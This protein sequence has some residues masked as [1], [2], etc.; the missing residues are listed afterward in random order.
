MLALG[1][2]YLNGWAMA[3]VDGARKERAEW[4]PHPDRVF[5][6]MAAAHFET[7][8][9]ATERA[10]LE[11]LESLPPPS[12]TASEAAE[13]RTIVSYV[14]VNDTTVGKKIPDNA[15]LGK[16]KDAGLSV[17]PEYRSRQPRSFPVAIPRDP[18][19][20]LIWP[21]AN[22]EAHATAITG[23][24][25]KVTHI[26]HSASLVQMWIEKS[27]PSA[28]W[29]PEKGLAERRLRI[30]DSGRLADLERRCNQ[31]ACL[32]YA[33]SLSRIDAAKGKEKK[34][35]QAEQSVRF[36]FGPPASRRPEP[37][38][39]HG[40]TRS[41]P[42]V[43]PEIAGSLFDPR[44]LVL[45]LSGRRPSLRATQKLV[46]A[47]RGALLA[48][49]SEPIPEWLSG[50]QEDGRPTRKPH[51]AILPLP[52]VD[53]SHADGRIM[54]I[55]LSLPRGI[56]PE[57]SGRVL[58]PMLIDENGLPRPLRLFDGQWLECAAEIEERE[59]PP[60]NLRPE[61]W[62]GPA[63]HW[64]TV[65][66]VVLDR[67][68][69]GKDRWEKAIETVKD[70]CERAGLPRPAEV[71]LHPVS[72][73]SGVPRSNEFS[74]ILRKQGGRLQHM[75]AIL[76]FERPVHGPVVIGAGRFRGYGLCRPSAPREG[77]NHV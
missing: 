44:L 19:V 15:D 62:T 63:R 18:D 5:M 27:P 54:G 23:L 57:E 32:E 66:P 77:E 56:P 49:C 10:A 14:P 26:G 64:A 73:V 20:H 50:H 13:R 67:H 12:L 59:T 24:C 35:L 61:T 71:L 76:S 3:A 39:W 17:V 7:D 22:P 47:L 43:G 33:D 37:G 68:H 42:V 69:D 4:P 48:A 41:Q 9:D 28:T 16:L 25:R 8:G 75:H 1:I 46:T 74:P 31:T 21:E 30:F 6:A 55:A 11:W 72:R 2:R 65:T 51:L 58:T 60:L 36:P 53:G 29:L 45:T 38:L 40:Y 34:I 52:F 70:A